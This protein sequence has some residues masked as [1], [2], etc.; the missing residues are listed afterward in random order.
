MELT[1]F[2]SIIY[3]ELKPWGSSAVN[4]KF[5]RQNLSPSFIKPTHSI[6]E[7]YNA[8]KELHKDKPNLFKEDG[9]ETYLVQPDT[10]IQHEILYPLIEISSEDPATST[11]KFYH[12]LLYNE[13][14]RLTDR[15]FKCINKDI[16][17]I[18][19]KE[20]I[21]NVV[22]SCKDLLLRIGT[23]QQ[24][25]P[26]TELTSY[27][28]PQLITNV[29]RFLK[30]TEKLYPQYLYDLPATINEL[31]GELLQQATPNI[32]I[33]KTTPEFQ[34]VSD[35]LLGIDDYKLE[36]D[37]R[38]SFGFNGDLVKLNSVLLAL[39]KH[40]EL[41]FDGKTS[42]DELVTVLTSKNLDLGAPQIHIGC[43]TNIFNHVWRKLK[44]KFNNLGATSLAASKLFYSKSDIL[45]SK[46]N[47]EKK[48]SDYPENIETIDNI[49]NQLLTLRK[50]VIKYSVVNIYNVNNLCSLKI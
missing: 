22:K 32:N 47:L 44:P 24:S 11:Q 49:I 19:K 18:Q 43:Q 35:I 9:L 48:V 42:V 37:S 46:S 6:N 21:Q 20:I 41:L 30:E 31:F 33:D 26:K 40:I 5:Y 12:F 50:K 23:D 28:I 15:V 27:V 25:F 8:L 4:E 38:F 45:L 34:T 39:N 36:K 10:H 29:I 14:T 2:K 16:E 7:Y 3:G 13:T 1:I 17:E